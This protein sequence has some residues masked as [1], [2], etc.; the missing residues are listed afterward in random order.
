M[1]LGHGIYLSLKN[2]LYKFGLGTVNDEHNAFLHKSIVKISG[3]FF[4]GKKAFLSGCIRQIDDLFNY[5]FGIIGCDLEYSCI[6]LKSSGEL[7][8]RS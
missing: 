3:R 5:R 4:K 2:T 8:K 7:R 1:S 6:A